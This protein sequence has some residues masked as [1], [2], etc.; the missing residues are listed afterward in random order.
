VTDTTD[1]KARLGQQE[2]LEASLLRALEPFLRSCLSLNHDINNPLAGII[3][4]AEFMADENFNL[5]QN[6]R[7]YIVQILECAERIQARIALL[8][9]AKTALSSDQGLCDYFDRVNAMNSLD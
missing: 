4:Y 8:T 7:N 5:T 6:Q 3:G 1:E 2:G 9:E